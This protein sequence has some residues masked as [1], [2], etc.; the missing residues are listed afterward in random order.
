MLTDE[1]VLVVNRMPVSRQGRELGAVVTLRDRTELEA[2]LRE[3]DSV[4]A[5]T[6]ALR[7]QQHEFS[8]RMHTVAGLIELG[9]HDAGRALRARRLG[10]QQ[11]AWPRR[12]ASGSSVPE[13]AAMLLAKTTVA[14][15]RGVAA[16]RCPTTPG[17]PTPASDDDTLLTIAGNLIDNA[18]DAAAAGPERQPE[19]PCT[20]A[21]TGGSLRIEVTDSGPGVPDELQQADLH[22]RLHD[23]GHRRPAPPRAR[24]GARAPARAPRGRHDH[25]HCAG[26]DAR[27][28]VTPARRPGATALREVE[29]MIRTLIVEDD[30]HVA[31]I[32]AAYVRRVPGFEVAGHASTLATAR[33]EIAAARAR[34]RAARP[35]P[36]RRPRA[37]PAARDARTPRPGPTSSSSPPPATWHSVRAAMQLGTVHYLVKPFRFAQLEERLIAYRRPPRAGSPGSARP[38]STRSTPCTACSAAPR[39]CPRAS[40]PRR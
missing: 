25:R 14:A 31:T 1:H 34:P 22:R 7:A 6:D 5:L 21:S 11:R 23:Q 28:R 8:N 26:H 16:A 20:L 13:I 3:L 39:R 17:S 15:E 12:S 19:V 2:L 38:S 30:Y 10:R 35:L 32:H 29:R 4:D 27:S 24:P 33:A 36:P 37:R 9:D 40:R 18:I